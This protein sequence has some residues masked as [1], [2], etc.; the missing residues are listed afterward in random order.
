MRQRYALHPDAFSYQ[1]AAVQSHELTEEECERLRGS[2]VKIF[3]I[4]GNADLMI[5]HWNTERMRTI[6][7]ADVKIVEGAG[8]SIYAELPDLVTDW[9][10]KSILGQKDD[11]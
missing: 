10:V 6:L 11:A 9:M 5:H 2:G 8:H 7:N 1:L 3:A 4:S